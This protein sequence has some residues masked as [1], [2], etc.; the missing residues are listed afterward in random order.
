MLISRIQDLVRDHYVFPD[1][2]RQICAA[3]DGVRLAGA[4]DAGTAVTL[5]AALQSVNGDRHL[6]VRHYP[7]GVPPADDDAST[8]AW[9]VEQA[10]THG[11]G[12][13][14]V[15]RLDG[16]IGLIDVGPVVL[17][18]EDVGPAAAAAFTLLRGV[19]RMVL[20]LRECVG[21]VPESV[22]LIVSH[23]T[24]DEPVH[25][26]D[27][28]TRDGTVTPTWTTPSVAPRL[29]L[30]VPVDVLTSARTFSGGE[31]LAYDLQALGR[32]RVVGETTGG[33]AHPRDAFDLGLHLQLHVPTARSVNAVTGTNWEGT[34]VVPDLPCPA[35]DALEVA[36]S[37]RSAPSPPTA[38]SPRRAAGTRRL[39]GDDMG[40]GRR[41]DLA[42]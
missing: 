38:R 24:G 12:I 41:I 7:D 10:R 2:A 21:G 8:R 28:V 37:T 17:L 27:L 39:K 18:P 36:L 13:T 22:A 26:Q 3:L 33:G 5:T 16:N 11:P 35:D 19:T 40:E 6:R 29:P 25:L 15:R 20:D 42:P 23:L 14:Q 9:L 30:D 4:D 31:E 32:A 1:V 34:G